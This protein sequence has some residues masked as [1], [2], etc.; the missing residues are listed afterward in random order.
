MEQMDDGLC[1]TLMCCSLL[2]FLGELL[3]RRD[4]FHPRAEINILL[5]HIEVKING[6]L[7]TT[8]A[9]AMFK[10]ISLFSESYF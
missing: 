6:N 4:S 1:S 2:G 3:K 8:L 7:L 9:T 5:Q 10:L